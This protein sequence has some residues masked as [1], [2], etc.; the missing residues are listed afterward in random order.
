MSMPTAG[1]LDELRLEGARACRVMALT[2][3]VDDVLGHVSIRVD[4]GKLL[5][6]CRSPTERGLLFTDPQDMRLVDLDGAPDP[7][8]G[9]RPPNELPIH[10]EL[11]RRFPQAGAVAHAHPPAVVAA[12]LAGLSLR[13]IVGAFD[14]PGTRM[15]AAGIPTYP[16]S[17]LIRRTELA[18]EMA[19]AMGTS[20]V[21]LLRGHGIVSV[22]ASAADA[23]LQ[24]VSVE[25]LARLSLDVVAAGGTLA[26]IP[27]ADMAEL[28]DLGPDFNRV[29]LWRHHLERLRAAGLDVPGFDVAE[30]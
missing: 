5:V 15:A 28:P 30:G 12:G 13:P 9:Y 20:P 29:M 4:E 18:A 19:E 14:I 24:A 26:D 16:R 3:L 17:V 7:G 27:A 8:D 6:R 21:C 25:R 23:V 11:L 10:T 1:E 22:G 2:G